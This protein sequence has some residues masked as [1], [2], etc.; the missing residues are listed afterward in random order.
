VAIPPNAVFGYDIVIDKEED[1]G[2]E[3]ET[4]IPTDLQRM[5][6]VL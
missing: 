1:D 4:Y 3:D 5:G 6:C 2:E